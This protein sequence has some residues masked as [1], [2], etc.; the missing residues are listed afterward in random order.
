MPQ[1]LFQPFAGSYCC[2]R[3]TRQKRAFHCPDP[4]PWSDNLDSTCLPTKTIVKSTS[5]HCWRQAQTVWWHWD[6]YTLWG[7]NEIVCKA[8]IMYMIHESKNFPP[9]PIKFFSLLMSFN[10]TIDLVQVLEYLPEPWNQW[11][12]IGDLEFGRYGHAIFSIGPLVEL[13]CLSASGGL[14]I[15][16]IAWI[17][18]AIQVTLWLSVSRIIK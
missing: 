6:F 17:G 2:W 15:Q 12:T 3:T 11:V 7:D 18:N 13:S 8:C 1:R 9:P 4:H 10:S 5:F 16:N 14:S